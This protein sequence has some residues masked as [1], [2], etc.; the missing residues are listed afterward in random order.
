M[1]TAN[2]FKVQIN[3]LTDQEY[4]NLAF[5][6]AGLD[7]VDFMSALTIATSSL[8]QIKISEEEEDVTL[9]IGV[10]N[11]GGVSLYTED[12]ETFQGVDTVEIEEALSILDRILEA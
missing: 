1:T 11:L 3:T 12:A 7:T 6:L 9:F 10:N 8:E 5:L 2:T 4:T